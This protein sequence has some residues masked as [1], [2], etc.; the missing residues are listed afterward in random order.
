[1]KRIYVIFLIYFRDS[2][3]RSA[4]RIL[5]KHNICLAPTEITENHRNDRWQELRVVYLLLSAVRPS[6]TRNVAEMVL[7]E[8]T[9]IPHSKHTG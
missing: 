7:F 4:R 8:D 5:D 6:R 2:Y 9:A 1:M 3:A